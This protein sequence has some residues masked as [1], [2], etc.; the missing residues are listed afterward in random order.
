[1][2]VSKNAR[3]SLRSLTSSAAFARTD[4]VDAQI[5]HVLGNGHVV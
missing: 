1:M 2:V 5:E 4:D 3:L